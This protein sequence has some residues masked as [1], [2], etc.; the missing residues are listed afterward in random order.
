MFYI[1]S[2]CYLIRHAPLFSNPLSFLSCFVEPLLT[3]FPFSNHFGFHAT[4][5]PPPPFHIFFFSFSIP[6]FF[7]PLLY[8]SFSLTSYFISSLPL[9]I[10][11]YFLLLL[12]LLLLGFPLD[13]FYT[14][15]SPPTPSRR[16]GSRAASGVQGHSSSAVPIK[17]VRWAGVTHSGGG[18]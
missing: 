13:S 12:L 4:P 17:G 16:M 8:S 11:C 15:P 1:K 2:F 3:F 6:L 5:C 7:P 18:R 14:L 9:F 10:Y